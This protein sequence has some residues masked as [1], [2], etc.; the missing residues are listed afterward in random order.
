M[1]TLT[2]RGALVIV[3]LAS[4][5]TLTRAEGPQA[6]KRELRFELSEAVPPIP[7]VTEKPVPPPGVAPPSYAATFTLKLNGRL[8]QLRYFKASYW[9]HRDELLNA[10]AEMLRTRAGQSMSELQRS[11]AVPNMVKY[12]PGAMPPPGQPAYEQVWT[13]AMTEEDARKMAEAFLEWADAKAATALQQVKDDLAK[14]RE[15]HAKAD[16]EIP[17]VEADMKAAQAERDELRKLIPA[18]NEDDVGKD[19]VE[20]DKALRS[21]AIDMAAIQAKVDAIN[22]LRKKMIESP[23]PTEEM[24]AF[25]NQMSATQDIDLAGVLARKNGLEAERKK[26]IRFRDLVT[27]IGQ[28]IQRLLDLRGE[29]ASCK[30]KEEEGDGILASP[31]AYLRPLE[32][33]DNKVTIYRLPEPPTSRTPPPAT[34]PGLPSAGPQNP[35]RPAPPRAK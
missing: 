1:T 7:Q 25:F 34:P 12:I 15:D 26:A 10:P 22:K 18:Y 3:A 23:R 2:R 29:I 13:L 6:P 5:C 32:V 14:T 19:I 17:E 9:R 35:P 28:D 27:R 31:P 33:V 8:D 20:L 4:V 30:M 16:K 24:V 11:C 21:V